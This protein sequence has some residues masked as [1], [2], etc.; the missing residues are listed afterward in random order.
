MVIILAVLHL[1]AFRRMVGKEENPN[2]MMLGSLRTVF[3]L[4]CKLVETVFFL[5]PLS[6]SVVCVEASRRMRKFPTLG[7]TN[8]LGAYRNEV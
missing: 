1:S 7:M 4:C 6:L 5:L 8:K 2:Y 3:A